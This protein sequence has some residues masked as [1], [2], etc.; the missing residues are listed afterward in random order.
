MSLTSEGQYIKADPE[1]YLVTCY[2]NE[3]DFYKTP[4]I[5]WRIAP[6]GESLSDNIVIP[7]TLS[8]EGSLGFNFPGMRMAILFPNGIVEAMNGDTY[9]N[10]FDFIADVKKGTS[11]AF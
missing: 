5:A 8:D 7:V 4:V 9:N 2:S 1:T 11:E 3:T 10:I 6:S